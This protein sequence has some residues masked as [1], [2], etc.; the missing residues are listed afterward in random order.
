MFF[1]LISLIFLLLA[2]GP[3]LWVKYVLWRYGKTIEA[4]PGTGAEL[5]E[6]LGPVDTN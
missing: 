3:S 6:H 2:F 4:M 1:G 5:A